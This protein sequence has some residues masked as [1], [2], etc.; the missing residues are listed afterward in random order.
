MTNEAIAA[1]LDYLC[2]EARNSMHTILGFMELAAEVPLDPSRLAS[3]ALG[4]A[5]A[6]QLLRSIDDVRELTGDTAS[7]PSPLEDLDLVL[8]VHETADVLNAA[9]GT[10]RRRITVDG[11]PD[12]LPMRQDRKGMEQVLTRVLRAALKLARGTQV[13]VRL[14]KEGSSGVRMAVDMRDKELSRRLVKWLNSTLDG[15]D[16]KGPGD[17]PF[18]VSVMVAGK[19]LRAMGGTAEEIQDAAGSG[20]VAIH[21]QSRPKTADANAAT[22]RS[23]D[24]LSV[25]VAE[26]CDESY[27]LTELMLQDEDVYRARDGDEALRTVQKRRFDLVLMDVHMPGMDGYS[28]IR[29]IRDWETQTGNSR[30]PLVVLSSDDLETQ[31][32][33]AAESGCSGFLRKPLRQVE[34]QSLV[35]RLKQ[36]RRFVM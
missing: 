17:M 13:F 36:S 6:D 19:R 33:S 2:T 12:T 31:Q 11:A 10:R 32:R 4:R 27:F 20:S 23:T 18:G 7:S 5:S 25:L 15:T 24:A 21:L 22:A 29:S 14:D 26:D 3:A 35:D 1:M 28:A 34:L 8:F 16:L 9:S 30:T